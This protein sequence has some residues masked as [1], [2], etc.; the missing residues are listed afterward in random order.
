LIIPARASGKIEIYF[1]S[2]ERLEKHLKGAFSLAVARAKEGRQATIDIM[3]FS[4]TSAP[5]ADSLMRI[6]RDYPGVRIRLIANLSQLFREPSSVVPDMADIA[7]GTK[8]GYQRSAERRKAMIKDVEQRKQAVDAE[9]KYLLSE[10]RQKAIPNIEIKYKWFPAFSWNEDEE[11]PDYDHFHQ[12]ASLLHHKAAIINGETLVNGSYNWSMSAE[13][14]NFE[15]LMIVS[16]PED[17]GIVTDFIAEFEAMW[18]NPEITKTTRECTVLQE[19]ICAEII[20]ER[21]ATLNSPK[22]Q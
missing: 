3:I 6:A 19:K 5:V 18:N 1:N 22:D 17:R 15:N 4:F 10:F 7:A 20:K 2:Q 14:K 11:E 9:F 21:E 12:K 13:T 8:E 16:G